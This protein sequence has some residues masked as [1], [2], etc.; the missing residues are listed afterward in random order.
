VLGSLA[1]RK[2]D[3]AVAE[4]A[5]IQ[6]KTACDGFASVG[7]FYA[8]EC[9]EKLKFAQSIAK[10]LRSDDP[11]VSKSHQDLWFCLPPRRC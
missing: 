5:V 3:L 4:E 6:L 1:Q 7:D 9:E 10:Q 2:H 8:G 11:T